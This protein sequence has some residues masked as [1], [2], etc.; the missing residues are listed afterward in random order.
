MP[1]EQHVEALE[2][3]D[4]LIVASDRIIVGTEVCDRGGRPAASSGNA[5]PCNSLDKRRLEADRTAWR[6][7]LRRDLG[8]NS[9]WAEEHDRS[10]QRER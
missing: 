2:Q 9:D 3:P 1:F 6:A 5:A 4:K 7:P 8:E 10:H